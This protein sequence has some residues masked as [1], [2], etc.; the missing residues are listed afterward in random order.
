LI[1][2]AQKYDGIKLIA[3]RLLSEDT[4][5]ELL[6]YEALLSLTNISS[7]LQGS[8]DQEARNASEMVNL[9]CGVNKPKDGESNVSNEAAESRTLYKVLIRTFIFEKNDRIKVAACE[10][11]SNLSLSQ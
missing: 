1:H 11:L 4:H 7:C 6:V 3:S 5:H 10:L 2:D 8:H 9:P